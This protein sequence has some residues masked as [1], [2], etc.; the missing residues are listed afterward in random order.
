MEYA[1]FWRRAAAMTLDG[2]LLGIVQAIVNIAVIAAIG[3]AA[4]ESEEEAFGILGIVSL[5]M[6][7]G[8]GHGGRTHLMSPVMAAAAAI[9]GHISD[10]RE[11]V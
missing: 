11:L 3:A 2:F 4:E 10:V 7:I 9:N 8:S 5:L 6:F 1:G